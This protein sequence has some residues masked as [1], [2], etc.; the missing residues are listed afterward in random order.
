MSEQKEE[1]FKEYGVSENGNFRIVGQIGVPHPYMITPKHLEYSQSIYLDIE[2][3]EQRSKEAHPNDP[4]RWA[5]CDICR[6]ANK[7]KGTPILSFSEHQVALV[8]ECDI[9]FSTA[10]HHIVPELQKYLL[11]IKEKAEKEKYAGFSFVKSKKLEG[12]AKNEAR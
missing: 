11:G 5:V 1:K 12:T 8:V 2:G 6:V 10:D 7:K 9:E 4:R 3:A